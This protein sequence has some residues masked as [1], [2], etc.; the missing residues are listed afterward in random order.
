MEGLDNIANLI[1]FIKLVAEGSPPVRIRVLVALFNDC[2][3]CFP[4][5]SSLVTIYMNIIS[6]FVT[7]VNI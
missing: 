3:G 5:V 1:R 6:L 4:P 2:H 7:S